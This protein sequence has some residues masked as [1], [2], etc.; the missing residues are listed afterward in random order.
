M[1]WW[2]QKKIRRW[3]ALSLV[4]YLVCSLV[5]GIGLAE[6]TLRVPKKP[7]KNREELSTTLE[8]TFAAQLQDVSIAAA[9]QAVLR[10]WY[11]RPGRANAS[12]VLLL[13]GVGDNRE[14]TVP[15]AGLFLAHGYAVLLPDSRAHGES[16]GEI[17]TYGIAESDDVHRWV[18][19]LAARPGSACV[20]G[21]GESM[22]AAIIL[23]AL[24]H[25]QRFCAV[26]AECPFSTFSEV[27]KDRVGYYVGL[28]PWLGRTIGRFGLEAA[29]VYA[30]LRYGLA[31]WNANPLFALKAS[32]TP[33]LLIHGTADRNI[34]PW[35]SVALAAQ[36]PGVELWLVPGASHTRAWATA[37]D[38]F[39]SRVLSFFQA[40]SIPTAALRPPA[41]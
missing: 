9:D 14:G 20:F 41:D 17:V 4:F 21:L 8:S 12:A 2:Q 33:T 35:H 26:V 36:A 31:L 29:S 1:R 6:M 32:R 38:E 39:E 19:W 16:G 7:L 3:V 40:H 30:R 27:S 28:G 18:S 10:A 25:E 13:H 23:Q 15:L 34:L 22:G 24:A 11:I 37:R 5:A